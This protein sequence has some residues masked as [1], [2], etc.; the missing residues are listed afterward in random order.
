MDG[1]EIALIGDESTAQQTHG[2]AV[3]ALIKQLLADKQ[4][5][6]SK[7]LPLQKA[8]LCYAPY[9]T[10]QDLTQQIIDRALE[11]LVPEPQAIRK[12]A[13]FEQTLERVRSQWVEKGQKVAKQVSEILTAHQKI[14]KQVK[15]KVN[16][17]WLASIADI[18]HQLDGL[19]SKDFVRIT[20]ETWLAQL[21]RYLQGLEKRLEKLD[22]DP[23]KDQVAI[24]Q[25]Q[26]LLDAYEDLAQEPAYA[27]AP[28]LVDFRWMLEELRLSLF[29]QPMKTLKPVSIQ[30]LEKQLKEF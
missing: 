1:F 24:R 23:A 12:Q 10:C 22:L 21:P 5:Y 30:R 11:Q 27:N 7:Q 18:Q 15:G 4:K 2:D 29:A 9:G 16:P 6:L 26:P 8:C 3:L 14:A 17:R 28:N 25:I 20:P 19:I 13:E